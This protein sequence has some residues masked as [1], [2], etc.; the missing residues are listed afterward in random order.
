MNPLFSIVISERKIFTVR[1]IV[2]SIITVS[3]LF[4]WQTVEKG[5]YFSE[6]SDALTQ[7][8]LELNRL[9]ALPDSS[10]LQEAILSSNRYLVKDWEDI[11]FWSE[12]TRKRTLE[13]GEI[14]SYNINVGSPIIDTTGDIYQLIFDI[15]ISPRKYGYR[16]LLALTK[17]IVDDSTI[18]LKINR[19]DVTGDNTLLGVKECRLGFNGWI[20]Q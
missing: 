11:A 2:V 3:I 1:V 18:N 19:I 10:Q 16:G 9:E 5:R 4:L 13:I 20:R 8:F 6:K 17:S 7:Y 14:L 12:R 15:S